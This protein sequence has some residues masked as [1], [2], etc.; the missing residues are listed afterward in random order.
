MDRFWVLVVAVGLA[1]NLEQMEM[2]KKLGMEMELGMEMVMELGME[3]ETV[4]GMETEME[5]EMEMVM[6]M[7]LEKEVVWFEYLPCPLPTVSNPSSKV[8]E[9][10]HVSPNSSMAVT[11]RLL[12]ESCRIASSVL[13]TKK[14]LA[15]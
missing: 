7:K 3:L 5:L 13:P 6:E 14:F 9:V 1:L 10:C 12:E 15:D 4:L 2:E 8:C 11:P